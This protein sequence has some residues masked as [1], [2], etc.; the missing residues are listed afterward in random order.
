MHFSLN[1]SLLEHHT[2]SNT[3]ISWSVP[4]DVILSYSIMIYESVKLQQSY[5]CLHIPEIEYLPAF[6]MIMYIVQVSYYVY[7]DQGNVIISFSYSH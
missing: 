5:I 6:P 2:L 7:Y 4:A 3:F 1:F